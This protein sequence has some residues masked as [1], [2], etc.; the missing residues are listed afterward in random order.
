MNESGSVR[1]RLAASPT[2]DPHLGTAYI[3][4]INYVM[5]RASHGRF[6]LR[7]EDTDQ[8]RST[9]Q[10]ELAILES[11]RW[12]GLSWDEGPDIGGSFGPYR[13]SERRSIYASEVQRLLDSGGAFI[14]FCTSERLA[15]VRRAQREAGETPRYD[16]HCLQLSADE[17]EARIKAGEPHVIRLRVPS[18][19][20]CTFTDVLRG[21][22]SIPWSQ[23]DMQVLMKSDGLPTYHFAVVVDDHY[24]KITHILR[25]EEWVSSCPK[26][27]LLHDYM[28]WEMPQLVHLPLLRNPDHTK[29]SKRKNPTSVNYYRRMGYLP[30]ALLNYLGTMGWSMPDEREIFSLDEMIEA[31]E[32]TKISLGGPVFDVEKLNWVNGQ[33]IRQLSNDDFT[34]RVGEWILNRE[35]LG[36]LIPMVRDRTERFADLAAQVDYLIGDRPQLSESDFSHK[37]LSLED[38]LR[39]LHHAERT[40]DLIECWD[41]SSISVA[42]RNLALAIDLKI[43]DALFPLF[44]AISGRSVALPLFDSMAFLGRDITR[45]RLRSSIEAAGGLSKKRRKNLEREF[46]ALDLRQSTEP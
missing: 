14:C 5:A 27:V 17:V 6:V 46:N 1:T 43:R 35:A 45:A 36:Q 10:S 25:G 18:E 32:P 13:C 22:I 11:L 20:D 42:I 28:G 23:V 16:G 29:M 40:V 21:E 15:Q 30:E 39:V 33:Y 8:Q 38:C 37:T 2:G 3:A 24:M 4:L 19:G 44:I 26:H 7:V 31:F 41:A 12:L 9:S 34:S